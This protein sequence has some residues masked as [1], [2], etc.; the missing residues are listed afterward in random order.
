MSQE[1]IK[2]HT[3]ELPTKSKKLEIGHRPYRIVVRMPNRQVRDEFSGSGQDSFDQTL[4]F[5]HKIA[6]IYKRS[7]VE[8]YL[9]SKLSKT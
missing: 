5:A 1:T 9:K 2:Q 8:V 6:G 7:T 3:Q 4:A